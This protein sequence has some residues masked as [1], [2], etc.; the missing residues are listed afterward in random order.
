MTVL[1]T[2]ILHLKSFK[3]LGRKK[4]FPLINDNINIEEITSSK[5]DIKKI[6]DEVHPKI[7]KYIPSL[8]KMLLEK[9]YFESEVLFK[10]MINKKIRITNI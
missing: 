7:L 4:I 2:L 6:L 10:Q 9:K 1:N 5:V 3:G 8:D